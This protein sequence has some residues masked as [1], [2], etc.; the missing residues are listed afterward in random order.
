V[1]SLLLEDGTTIGEVPAI[2]RYIEEIHPAPPLLGETA[3][4]KA[5]VARRRAHRRRGV[6]RTL[7]RPPG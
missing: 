1:P 6:G 3:K 7:G 4:E 2:C 5:Q